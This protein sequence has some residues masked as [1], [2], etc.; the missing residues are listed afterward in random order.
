MRSVYPN[1]LSSHTFIDEVYSHSGLNGSAYVVSKNWHD[2]GYEEEIEFYFPELPLANSDAVIFKNGDV[3]LLL[4][5]FTSSDVKLIYNYDD[6]HFFFEKI[7]GSSTHVSIYSLTYPFDEWIFDSVVSFQVFND[8]TYFDEL[9]LHYN[10]LPVMEYVD[11]NSV[12]FSAVDSSVYSSLISHNL[13]V[14]DLFVTSGALYFQ[15]P[16]ETIQ[17]MDGKDTAFVFEDFGFITAAN[18]SFVDF[19][20][21]MTFRLNGSFVSSGQFIGY[22]YLGFMDDK[23]FSPGSSEI[24]DH[25]EPV[26]FREVS[27]SG[28]PLDIVVTFKFISDGYVLF[29]PGDFSIQYYSEYVEDKNHNEIVDAIGGISSDITSSIDS[30]TSQIVGSIDSVNKNLEYV[31]SGDIGV[32]QPD[33]D[34]SELDDIVQEQDEI[35]G[36]ILSSLDDSVSDSIPV[37]YNNYGDYLIDNIKSFKSSEFDNTFTFIRS[38]FDN[39]V[40]SLSIMPLLLFSLSFGFAVFALGR[41]LR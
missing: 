32:P 21:N 9:E 18:T 15:I 23:Y 6:P 31:I 41:R 2:Y 39:L 7:S 22:K 28:V 36:D 4:T 34:T 17:N 19:R 12:W 29:F 37:G 1:R 40:A 38:T 24:F 14:E 20:Y 10:S 16:S 13:T 27:V 30:S 25:A 5:G 8:S 11:Y 3:Y 26:D 35:I 33:L